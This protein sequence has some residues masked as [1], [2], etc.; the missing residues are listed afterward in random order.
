MN[1]VEAIEISLLGSRKFTIIADFPLATG[2]RIGQ[3]LY[4]GMPYNFRELGASLQRAQS[5]VPTAIPR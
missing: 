3:R 5:S 1:G 2:P 4:D